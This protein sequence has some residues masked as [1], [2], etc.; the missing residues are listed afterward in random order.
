MPDAAAA[1]AAPKP[2][3]GI[4]V[5]DLTQNL[6]GPACTHHLALMGADI[7]KVERPAHG[8][9][10][11]RTGFDDQLRANGMGTTFLS[12]NAGKKS[13][14]IDLGTDEGCEIV[15]RLALKCDVV[16]ENNRAG[17]MDRLG[18][19]HEALSKINPRLIY[20]AISGFGQTGPWKDRAAYDHIV[21]AASGVMNYAGADDGKP[22][23]VGIPT[24]DIFSA[25]MAAFAIAGALFER[26]HTN[27]GRFI[28]V[29]MFD[30]MIYLLGYYGVGALLSGDNPPAMGSSGIRGRPASGTFETRDG[31]L[32][33]TI[34]VPEQRI[35]LCKLI[36]REDLLD[37]M[38]AD[39]VEFD[40]DVAAA[41]RVELQKT[42][43]EKT[44]AEWEDLLAGARLPGVRVRTMVEALAHPQ[45][46]YR[47]VLEHFSDVPGVGP[48][49][50]VPA[51]AFLLDG[52]ALA[53]GS[54][55]PVLGAHGDEILGGLG[56]GVD[57]IS[58]LRATGVVGSD[59]RDSAR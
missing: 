2:L 3:A 10:M 24:V 38:A 6:S 27:R 59:G 14:L 57:D 19:G 33:L 29:A 45:M 48:D 47:G 30:S 32:V 39:V 42:L 23:L 26:Q 58:R 9:M 18:L 40:L 8:D 35:S 4:T 50:T 13:I 52:Q 11:R 28:D 56:Y 25:L 43:R 49:L 22:H 44:A 46:P 15:R 53:T 5:L 31:R 54:P 17:A 41:L 16:V 12:A 34:F 36:G 21:Q 55:P 20:C 51:A 37:R 1:H 7:L